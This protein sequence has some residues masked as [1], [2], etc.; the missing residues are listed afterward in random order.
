MNPIPP[1]SVTTP[2]GTPGDWL[3]GFHTGDDYSTHGL[4]GYHVQATHSGRVTY[5]GR[6]Q[7]AAY[8]LH[9]VVL[10]PLRWV[11]VRYCHLSAAD[12]VEGQWVR[13]GDL[14]GRSGN[15]G[16]SSGPHLHYE[17]RVRPFRY[18]DSRRPR[19]NR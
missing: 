18:I 15:S 5:V 14:V 10:G 9:V 19:F 7:G 2:Y 12:V 13:R 8:G 4:L 3:L 1:L 11:Q 16:N 17:E 6:G